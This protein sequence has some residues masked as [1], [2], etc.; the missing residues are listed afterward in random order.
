M[1]YFPLKDIPSLEAYRDLNLEVLSYQTKTGLN[2]LAWFKPAENEQE[3][4]IFFHGNKSGH[5]GNIYFAKPYIKEGYGFFSLSY[6]GYDGNEGKPTEES[7]YDVGRSALFYMIQN[8]DIPEE[9]IILHGQS[10]GT[11]VAVQMATEFPNVKAVILESPYTSLP[12]V[13][14]KTY[15][16]VP[17]RTLMKDRFDSLSKAHDIKS[18]VFII[19]GMKDG[20]IPPALGKQL[21]NDI[22]TPK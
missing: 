3:T 7:L 21:F 14:A 11:G 13:A 9:T 20:V 1:I 4:I 2:L 5:E 6:P 18:P 8:L 17:V 22:K 15:F 19:Q 10:L 12:D 16:F